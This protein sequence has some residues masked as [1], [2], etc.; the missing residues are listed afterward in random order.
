MQ[1]LIKCNKVWKPDNAADA[2]RGVVGRG[3]RR[4]L[5][6]GPLTSLLVTSCSQ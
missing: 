1:K 5:K 4:G 3:G 6:M 2:Q